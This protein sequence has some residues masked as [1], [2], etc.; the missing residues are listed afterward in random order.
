MNEE[1][2]ILTVLY[3]AFIG[4]IRNLSVIKKPNQSQLF[5]RRRYMLAFVWG[6]LCIGAWYALISYSDIATPIE[7]KYVAISGV[8]P[9]SMLALRT[10]FVLSDMKIKANES[11]DPA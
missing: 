9:A 1:W 7:M 2:L 5:Y 11:S 6:L 4:G 3:V 10:L 8:V